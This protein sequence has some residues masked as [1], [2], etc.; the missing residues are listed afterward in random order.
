[1]KYIL[2]TGGVI[3]GIGK[4]IIAS[5]VG[6]IL[7]SCGLHVTAIKIDPYINI[8]AGTFSPYEHGG[9]MSCSSYL[10]Y[11]LTSHSMALWACDLVSWVVQS[12][13]W[14]FLQNADRCRFARLVTNV[15]VILRGSLCSR[16]WRRSWLGLGKLWA[17]FGHPP[18]QGQQ[19]HHWKDLPVSHQQGEER[20]LL[21][22]NCAGWVKLPRINFFF[23]CYFLCFFVVPDVCFLVTGC[24]YLSLE[25]RA[26]TWFS[27][28]MIFAYF[29]LGNK[30]PCLQWSP[31]SRMPS[32]NG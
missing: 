11:H 18:D 12:K 24:F 28:E 3:S 8:D 30:K 7:K 9:L 5:S 29:L 22:Q 23:L 26:V 31:T 10:I 2:V 6:T 14:M 21:G 25:F 4:G 1:M 16:R 20:R 32:R 13:A 19:P 27:G 15:C 17:F